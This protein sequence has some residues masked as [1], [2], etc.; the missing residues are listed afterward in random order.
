[1]G[2]RSRIWRTCLDGHLTEMARIVLTR[3]KTTAYK[4]NTVTRKLAEILTD[5]KN[6]TSPRTEEDFK[7]QKTNAEKGS[8][9][10]QK[11]EAGSK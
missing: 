11:W 10:G 4:C 9:S 6:A 2:H 5:M 3:W 8:I 1:M 7:L